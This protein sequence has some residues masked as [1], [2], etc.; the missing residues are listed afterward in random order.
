MVEAP[1]EEIYYAICEAVK[2]GAGATGPLSDIIEW[3]R[4]S[5]DIGP[6][7]PID[8]NEF[9]DFIYNWGYEIVNDIYVDMEGFDWQVLPPN[10]KVGLIE[11]GQSI[12]FNRLG[13]GRR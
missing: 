2:L 6:D 3:Y 13:V 7:E 10:A 4:E 5:E 9:Y 1:R 11:P 12:K 8:E